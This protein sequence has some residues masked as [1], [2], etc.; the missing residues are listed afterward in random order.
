MSSRGIGSQRPRIAVEPDR[1]Y[2]DGSQAAELCAAFG[3]ALDEW[4]RLVLG[5]WLARDESDAFVSSACGLSVPRQN[6]KNA[7]LEARELYGI[8][9]IGER[10]LHTAHRVDTARKS[11]LRLA[12]FFERPGNEELAAMVVSIRRTNGQESIS[13]ANG[14]S[15][16]FSSRVNG[17]ARGSTYDAVAF[18]EAQEL[19]DDQMES[20]LSTMAAA[21]LGNR[22][23]V[24]TGTPPS[25]VSPGTVF[26]RVRSQ[27][28]KGE[29]P[30]ISWHE[31]SVEEPGDVSDRARWYEAN[32]AL[33]IRLDEGFTERELRTLSP[34]GFARE[35]LGW[36]SESAQ[37][38]NA[39]IGAAA[40]EACRVEPTASGPGD[41][42]AYGVK[43]SPDGSSY[44]L[45]AAVAC[46]DRPAP[47]VECLAFEGLSRGVGPLA[48]WLHERKGS[49]AVVVID[50][51]ANSGALYQKLME[52]G[53]PRRAAMIA[54]PSDACA[55][56]S[57]FVSRV[58]GGEVAHAGQEG[59][60]RSALAAQR[61]PI[62]S[63]GGWGF[64]SGG[65]FGC[66]PVESAALALWGVLTTKR[67][68]SRKLKVG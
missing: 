13:L 55:A 58:D 41:R 46:R 12:S 53:F 10:I 20:I 15:I 33:G 22:Q 47:F 32:P 63:H 3:F 56:A 29:D 26:R 40:W 6:G 51:K 21:P 50:G 54:S 9:V 27:A 52:L 14:G 65:G 1:A 49:A 43:F 24:Y 31:W 18:D 61:R 44:A 38:P 39:V 11:F 45:S 17:G 68:P 57:T 35:R 16:E 30:R 25:P 2:T 60:T 37:G 5:S 34:D 28:V 36:W 62:G 7:V 4:Q 42:I 66:E 48:S 19:T 64:G 59:L 67:N 23:L 8:A